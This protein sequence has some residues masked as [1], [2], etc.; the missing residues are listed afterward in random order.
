[1]RAEACILLGPDGAGAL[2][3]LAGVDRR[4]TGVALAQLEPFKLRLDMR[5]PLRAA[6]EI[7]EDAAIIEGHLRPATA[8]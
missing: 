1:M 2:R 6:V 7:D 4:Q 5:P 8:D 3:Q